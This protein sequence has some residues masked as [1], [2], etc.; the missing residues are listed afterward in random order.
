VPFDPGL[1]DGRLLILL[2][3]IRLAS[4]MPLHS[5]KKRLWL[6]HSRV[7]PNTITASCKGTRIINQPNLIPAPF[8]LSD[9]VAAG[10][11][12]DGE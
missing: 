8:E 1:R 5:E 12:T 6:L 7:R 4:Q 2:R 11:N 3:T 9:S 10:A